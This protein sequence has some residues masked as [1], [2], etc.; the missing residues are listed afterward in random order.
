MRQVSLYVLCL[1]TPGGWD[2]PNIQQIQKK[3]W[4]NFYHCELQGSRALHY[5]KSVT[6]FLQFGLD[7]R[8]SE[9]F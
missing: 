1:G 6:F 3:S 2:V 5:V 7:P 9:K 8:F 4:P